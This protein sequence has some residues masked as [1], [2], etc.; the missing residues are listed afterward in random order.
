MNV[1]EMVFSHQSSSKTLV[2]KDVKVV[3]ILVGYNHQWDNYLH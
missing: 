2:L 1:G 3:Q